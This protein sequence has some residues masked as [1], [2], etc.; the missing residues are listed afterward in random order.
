MSPHAFEQ[1]AIGALRS[2]IDRTGDIRQAHFHRVGRRPFRLLGGRVSQPAPCRAHVPEIAADEVTLPGI[3]VQ[4]GR[5]RGIGVRLR[6]SIAESGAHRP[7][8]GAGS[9]VQLR[10]G[11]GKARLGHVAESTGFVAVD[12][13]LLVVQHQLTEQL[14]L[15][16]LIVRRGG[17]PLDRLRLD[18]VNLGLD[19]R[20]FQ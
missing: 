10:H 8:I 17:Q 18:A 11:T 7:R 6:F 3:V 4:H 9:P 12:R 5:E 1:G 2:A 14:D 19:L 16:D 13:E 20:N 15:L